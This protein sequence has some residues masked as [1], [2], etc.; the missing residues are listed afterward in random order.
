ADV[1][2]PATECASTG[3]ALP[4]QHA[5]ALPALAEAMTLGEG[6]LAYV[7]G[8]RLLRGGET[9]RHPGLGETLALLAAAGADRFYTGELADSLVAEVRADGGT[10]GPEDLAAYQVRVFP[11]DA[12]TFDTH[13]VHGRHDLLD[14]LGAFGRL[15]VDIARLSPGERAVAVAGNLGGPDGPGDTTNIVAVDTAGDACVVTTSLGLGSGVWLPGRGVHLNSML[16]EAE[17]VRGSAPAGG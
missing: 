13:T 3:T 11:A 14:T 10:V 17:L 2:A 7:V 6:R 12:V 8:D 1:V 15:P 5:N 4:H 16:G 9:L